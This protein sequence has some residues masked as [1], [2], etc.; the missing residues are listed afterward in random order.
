MGPFVAQPSPTHPSG[1]N[2]RDRFNQAL[3]C[4][5]LV[6][7]EDLAGRHIQAML[8]HDTCERHIALW[9]SLCPCSLPD[10]LR[11]KAG[12]NLDART[13]PEDRE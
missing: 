10:V 1:H 2:H 5:Q 6:E 11:Q 13:H 8:R 12:C 4:H 9:G 3:E 7:A